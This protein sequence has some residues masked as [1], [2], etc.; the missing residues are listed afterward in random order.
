M[1]QYVNDYRLELAKSLIAGE[2]FKM[3]DISKMCGYASPGYFAKVFK[4]STGLTPVEYRRKRS[5]EVQGLAREFIVKEKLMFLFAMVGI[6]PLVVT[7]AAI[8]GELR[9]HHQQTA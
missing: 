8:Y 6:I 7:F 9:F 2:H 4:S 5:D 1:K 3:A